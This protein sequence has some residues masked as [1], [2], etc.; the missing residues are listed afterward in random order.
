MEAENGYT[1][2]NSV[3]D[4]I[5]NTNNNDNFW[6]N[7]YNNL[8]T[9]S[10]G[11]VENLIEKISGEM[12]SF[13]EYTDLQEEYE[14]LNELQN[15]NPGD[16]RIAWNAVYYENQPIIPSGEINFTQA[17]EDYNLVEVHQV[18][19]V[20][21]AGFLA[22]LCTKGIWNAICITLGVGTALYDSYE[23]ENGIVDSVEDY[24]D[25]D[26]GQGYQ[27]NIRKQ[28][29]RTSVR[30]KDTTTLPERRRIGF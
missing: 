15:T 21:I 27:L 19:Q 20:I 5:N 1:T 4:I 3:N 7:T 9:L 26:T 6:K 11:D 22:L 28:R 12:T 14:L 17:V 18:T 13:T 24:Y 10:S 2:Q 29:N 30:R 23:Q 8:F 16:F 25:T